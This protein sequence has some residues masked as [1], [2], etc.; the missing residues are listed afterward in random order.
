MLYTGFGTYNIQAEIRA[1]EA[2]RE[3]QRGVEQGHRTSKPTW[4]KQGARAKRAVSCT[5]IGQ[6]ISVEQGQEAKAEQ[7]Q[8]NDGRV[9]SE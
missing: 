4:S 1:H 3:P 8:M 6:Y 5:R 7:G 2:R 9:V